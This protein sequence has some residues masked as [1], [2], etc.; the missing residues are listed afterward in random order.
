[1]TDRE[2]RGILLGASILVVLVIALLLVW[3][4]S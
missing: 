4:W 1:M 2:L 3:M